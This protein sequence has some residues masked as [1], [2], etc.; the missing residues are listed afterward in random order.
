M[1]PAEALNTVYQDFEYRLDGKVDY[2]TIMQPDSEGTL[3][4]DCE[5]FA[6]TVAYRIANNSIILLFWHILIFKSVIWYAHTAGGVSHAV[7][8]HRGYGYCDNI[9][10][11][12]VAKTPHKKKFPFLLPMVLFKLTVSRLLAKLFK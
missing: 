6:I 4:G 7:L 3:N 8:Y 2:W 1:T 10:P 11:E 9:L 12:W 5:D